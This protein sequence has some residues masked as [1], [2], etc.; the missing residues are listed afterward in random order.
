MKKVF[1]TAIITFFAYTQTQA[2]VTFRPTLR[3]GANFSHFTKGD[4]YNYYDNN[5]NPVGAP[6]YKSKTDF[7][8]G[9]AGT[10]HLT[11]HYTLQPEFD[12]S[13]QGSKYTYYDTNLSQKRTQ[14]L[15]VSY[16][17]IAIVNKF[18]FNDKFNVHIGP[19][20]DFVVEKSNN[21]DPT[22]IDLAF[23]AGLGYSFT[24]NFG[25]EARIKKGIIPVNDDYWDD[26]SDSNHTNVVFSVGAVYTFDIK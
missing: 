8:V 5:G 14:Q 6:E 23:I 2:Q 15:D 17:S 3:A 25:I 20:V 18:T 1:L 22:D 11:K 26:G 4:D 7:Y 16:L 21:F 9:F 10:L 24:K 13:R 19:T 12:Y